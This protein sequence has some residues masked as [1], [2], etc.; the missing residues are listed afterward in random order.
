MIDTGPPRYRFDCSLGAGIDHPKT[1]G[2]SPQTDAGA[3]QLAWNGDYFFLHKRD[4]H[5]TNESTTLGVSAKAPSM[6]CFRCGSKSG[7]NAYRSVAI[8][9]WWITNFFSLPHLGGPDVGWGPSG[10]VELQEAVDGE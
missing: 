4:V 6:V 2:L 9:S 8:Y 7:V 1:I 5:H 3:Q 10:N